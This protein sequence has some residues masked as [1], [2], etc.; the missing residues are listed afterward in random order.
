MEFLQ[1]LRYVCRVPLLFQ[2]LVNCL[3]VV[4]AN[5]VSVDAR[6]GQECLEANE[7]F[8]RHDLELSF[9]FVGGIQRV[10]GIPDSGNPHEARC[11]R[12]S[13]WIEPETPEM[14]FGDL[15]GIDK[16]RHQCFDLR[17]DI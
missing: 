16:R 5:G 12:K 2:F 7:Y 6:L 17:D 8:A 1:Y 11:S 10:R 3:D 4:M 13:L 14:V 15:E 9:R